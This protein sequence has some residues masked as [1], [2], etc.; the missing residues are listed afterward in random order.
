M[1]NV[2]PPSRREGECTTYSYVKVELSSCDATPEA[3]LYAEVPALLLDL[4][5]GDG[6]VYNGVP[7]VDV[8]TVETGPVAADDSPVRRAVRVGLLRY[9]HD[10]LAAVGHVERFGIPFQLRRVG[11]AHGLFLDVAYHLLAHQLGHGVMDGVYPYYRITM[12]DL[13]RLLPVVARLPCY[14]YRQYYYKYQ[15][16]SY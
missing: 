15:V 2:L 16:V 1:Y 4:G 9:R 6:G 10:D 12:H 5:N 7:L 3:T 13:L 14:H 8:Y 11:K